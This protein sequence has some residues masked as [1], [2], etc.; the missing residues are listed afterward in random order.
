VPCQVGGGLRSEDDV[1]EVL[2]WGVQRI[3]VGTQA[4]K[5]PAW[6]ESLCRQFPGQVVLGIDARDGKVATEG[7]LETSQQSALELAKRCADSPLAAVV[8]TDIACDGM[9][10]GPNFE[11]LRQMASAVTVPVIA[12][13]GVTTLEDIRRLVPL[14]LAGCIVGRALYEGRLDLAE[15]LSVA[16]G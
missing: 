9:M 12:S 10:N 15:A 4:V 14:G 16:S 2:S 7:W 13:G 11:G 5:D 8:Y 6:L 1:A 3:V